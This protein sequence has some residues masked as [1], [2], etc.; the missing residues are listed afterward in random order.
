MKLISFTANTQNT[1]ASNASVLCNWST[2][3]EENSSHFIVERSSNGRTFTSIRTV[4]A[5]GNTSSEQHYNYVDNA[6]Q[7]GIS[8]YRLKMIDKDGKS[9]YSSIVTVT[10]NYN[11]SLL[12]LYP[13]PVKG[14]ATLAVSS[15]KIQK[16]TYGIYDQAGKLIVSNN[17]SLKNGINAFALPVS[18]LSA[19]IYIIKLK[20]ESSS[21]Q[22][23]FVKQ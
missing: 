17:V 3:S 8:Y 18:D 21:K 7:K 4:M 15:D 1:T 23:Q 9:A 16:A 11:S 14:E 13:N 5:N 12:T 22:T 6:P 20:T 10:L 19:G 2:A